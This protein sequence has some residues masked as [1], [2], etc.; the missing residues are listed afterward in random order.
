MSYKD[1]KS[2]MNDLKEIYQSINE[3]EALNALLEFKEKWQQIY[4]SCFKSWE[5]NWD[6]PSAFFAY[7]AEVWKIIYTT[8]PQ[9]HK[10]QAVIYQ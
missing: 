1:I 10:K 2:F 7:P 4:P 3:D 8:T 9:G 5:H 6:I